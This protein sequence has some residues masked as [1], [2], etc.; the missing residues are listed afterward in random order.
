MRRH[1]WSEEKNQLIQKERSISFEDVLFQI[2]SG[3]LI[4]IIPHPN[5]KDYPHQK[6]YL[7]NIDD[8]VYLVPFVEDDEKIFMKTIIPSRKATKKYLKERFEN[9]I[10]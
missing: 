1:D 8:Y 5:Q 6:V 10:K 7:V 4:G 2:E 3:E 9:E